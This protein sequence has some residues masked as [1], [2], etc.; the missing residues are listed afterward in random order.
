MAFNKV[1]AYVGGAG[2]GKTTELKRLM[3]LYIKK[4]MKVLIY[5]DFDHPSYRD[6][7][8]ITIAQLPYWKSGIYRLIH[9]DSQEA[10]AA[11]SKYVWNALIVLEDCFKYTGY[12]FTKPMLS[13]IINAKQQN[14][15]FVFMY[16]CWAWVALD[17]S[18]RCDAYVVFKTNDTPE[19]RFTKK[20][21]PYLEQLTEVHK[22]VLLDTNDY[23][24]K[25]F[26]TK[27][28]G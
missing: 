3:L 5:D 18:R 28:N 11:I 2:T 8:K 22:L 17:L 15:D 23:K 27:V 16:H 12:R 14:C 21:A 13:F 6:V 1:T 20:D 25:L 24:K 7:P 10:F 4:G 9:T 19:S 26:K